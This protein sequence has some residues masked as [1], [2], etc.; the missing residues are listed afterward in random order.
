MKR[1]ATESNEPSNNQRQSHAS[2][3]A[4]VVDGRKQDIRGL[5]VRN[6]RYY[7]RLAFED[8]KTGN[9]KVRRV[10]LMDKDK[11]AVQSVAQAVEALNR[12]KVNRSDSNLPVLHRCPRFSD[13]VKIY[14]DFIRAGQ[15]SG[16]A[17]KKAA[18]IIREEGALKQ[19]TEDLGGSRLDKISLRHVHTHIANRLKSGTNK[20][21]VKID[22]IVLNNLLNHAVEEKW[23]NTVPRLSKEGRKRLGSEPKKRPLFTAEDLEKLCTAAMED[24][25]DGSPV[26]KNWLQFCDYIRL[27]AYCGA[28]EQEALRLRWPDV[29]FKGELLTIGSDGDTKNSTARTVDFNPK[30]KAHLQEM[31]KRRAPDSDWLFPSPQR[32]DRDIPA[33]TFRESLKLVRAHA[34]KKHPHL[35]SKAFHDLRHCF[36]SYCVMSGIDF[37]TVSEWLGHCDGGVL[38]CQVYAHLTDAH[39]KEQAQR[40]NFVSATKEQAA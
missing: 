10:A 27:L 16:Q 11:Q 25:E 37:K 35:A 19:W 21:T 12:L 29:D 8:P 7:A 38:V 3:F 31:V 32:G 26:T 23:I 24:N 1:H 34:A 6:G 36:A 33:K 18:T 22:I 20:R 17:L 40:L 2:S 39:K 4:K 14:L 30:L 28:R 5:W 9:K 13:Y 15:D